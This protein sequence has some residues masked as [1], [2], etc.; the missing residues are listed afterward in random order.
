MWK[1]R[2]E[3][4][5]RNPTRRDKIIAW[6]FP[7]ISLGFVALIPPLMVGAGWVRS[8]AA[9][10]LSVFAP[11]MV[12]GMTIADS[13][14]GER[15]R[16]TLDT[17]LASRL[18]DRAILF[19]KIGAPVV[20]AMGMT[21]VLHVVSLAAVNAVHWQGALVLYSFGMAAMLLALALLLGLF[22]ASLGVV[23]SLRAPTVQQATQT[24]MVALLAP[25]MVLS[26]IGLAIAHVVPDSWRLAF[27]G[28]IETHVAT[29]DFGQVMLV[30]LAVLLV[31]DLGLMLAATVRFQRSRLYEN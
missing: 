1:E 9:V 22:T 23:V 6:V 18:P 5:G 30:I 20:Q 16:H 3:L 7:V 12:I 27:K 28:L 2:R 10:S 11:L 15:E 31:A 29:A 4:A 21:V 24:M 14:A 17:L 25:V 13:F 19:G 26:F 8:P